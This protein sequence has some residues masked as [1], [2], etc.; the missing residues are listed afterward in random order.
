MKRRAFI[1]ICDGRC[2]KRFISFT[3]GPARR[4]SVPLRFTLIGA[5]GSGKGTQGEKL[6][7]DYGLVSISTGNLLRQEQQNDTSVGRLAKE[8]MKNGGFVS[9]DIVF[10]LVK[11]KL[12]S[13]PA[14]VAGWLLDG[15]PRTTAQAKQLDEYLTTI[16][17]PLLAALYINV[18][19]NIIADRVKDRRVHLP[20]GRTYHLVWNPPKVPDKDDI[21][22]EPLQR[23]SDDEPQTVIARLKKFEDKIQ[24]LL[25]YYKQKNL[26]FDVHSPNSDIGY[27]NI[28]T[29]IAELK[30]KHPYL[31]VTH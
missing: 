2:Q 13:L 25:D 18:D 16:D 9:D 6:E 24:P 26:L 31:C 3:T 30:E 4:T 1:R 8:Q 5:P 27:Y 17:S 10:Q 19:K 20:S 11:N 22:G 12:Q 15:Y 29:I 7:R 14:G 21:T 28:N 23:R